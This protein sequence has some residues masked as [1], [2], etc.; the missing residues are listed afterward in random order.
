MRLVVLGMWFNVN[1]KVSVMKHDLLSLFKRI[2]AEAR[3]EFPI[4]YDY[5]KVSLDTALNNIEDAVAA[6]Q[7]YVDME[8]LIL[9]YLTNLTNTLRLVLLQD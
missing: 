6:A 1:V 8:Y 4:M 7:N 3:K 9:M 5:F 2:D